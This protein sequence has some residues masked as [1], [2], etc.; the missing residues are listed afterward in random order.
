MSIKRTLLNTAVGFSLAATIASTATAE[1]ITI[2][3][4]N[5][6]DM[7]TM[8]ELAP[9]WEEATGNTINWVVLEENVLRQRSKAARLAIFRG[10]TEAS[11]SM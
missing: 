6:A 5:N 9:K 11:S 8:Q 10:S 3:T 2:A 4:V 1:E 7:I